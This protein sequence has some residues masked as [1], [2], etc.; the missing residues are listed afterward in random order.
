MQLIAISSGLFMQRWVI[1][2]NQRFARNQGHPFTGKLQETAFCPEA[3]LD[4][5]AL[6]EQAMQ[7]TAFSKNGQNL[8]PNAIIRPSSPVKKFFKK[9][10]FHTCV[11]SQM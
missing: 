9:T 7:S 5:G 10:V 4:L 11:I 3:H 1:F 6:I 2:K 8:M